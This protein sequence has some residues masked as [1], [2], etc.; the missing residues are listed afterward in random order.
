M[1]PLGK[2]LLI[3]VEDSEQTTASGI[4]LPDTAKEKPSIGIILAVNK[5]SEFVVGQKVMFKKWGG[6][7]VIGSDTDVLVHEDDLLAII[8]D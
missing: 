3:R 2:N 6:N 5:G 8:E 7:E 1:E 4:V